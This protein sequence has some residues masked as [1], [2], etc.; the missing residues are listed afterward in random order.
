MLVY[1][2]DG[3]AQTILRAAKPRQKL[4]IKLS[5]SPSHSILTSGQPVPALTLYRQAPGRVA[6]GVPIFKSLV[7]LDPEKSCRKPD[8][9]P[10]SSVLEADALTTKP[11]RWCLCLK[12]TRPTWTCCVLRSSTRAECVVVLGGGWGFTLRAVV[13]ALDPR[14]NSVRRYLVSPAPQRKKKKVHVLHCH[15]IEAKFFFCHSCLKH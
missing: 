3:H 5:T 6:T 7:W 2:R 11:M 1:L 9:D 13:L 12:T 15:K 14:E 8:S 10:G 4:Q